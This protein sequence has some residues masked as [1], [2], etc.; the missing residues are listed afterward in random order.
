MTYEL[1]CIIQYPVFGIIHSLVT[2]QRRALKTKTKPRAS[3]DSI[4]PRQVNVLF[5][6]A[7]SW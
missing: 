1:Y 5:K 7:V 4:G 3:S 6:D 2:L